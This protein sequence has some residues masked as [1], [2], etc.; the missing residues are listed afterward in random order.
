MKDLI[1]ESCRPANS[2]LMQ[3]PSKILQQ[4]SSLTQMLWLLLSFGYQSLEE[5]VGAGGQEPVYAPVNTGLSPHCDDSSASESSAVEPRICDVYLM[6]I[7]TG[8]LTVR[9]RAQKR[10]DR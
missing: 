9:L 7:N 8:A 2:Y 6:K 4:W 1:E 3:T 5:E 10:R